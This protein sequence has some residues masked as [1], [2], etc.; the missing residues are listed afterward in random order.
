MTLRP[1]GIAF[2]EIIL[3]MAAWTVVLL[4][5]ICIP[6]RIGLSDNFVTVLV[7]ILTPLVFISFLPFL[8]YVARS[9]FFIK[10]EGQA[11]PQAQLQQ[12]LEELNTFDAP[13]MLQPK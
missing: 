2:L 9:V 13:V 12:R 8:N 1:F 11:I 3:F 6:P 4:A 10:G 5:A 7:L